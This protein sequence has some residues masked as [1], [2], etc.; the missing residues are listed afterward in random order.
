MECRQKHR[1]GHGQGT[2]TTYLEAA[3]GKATFL[4]IRRLHAAHG[5]A[6][7]KLQS[8]VCGRTFGEHGGKEHRTCEVKRTLGK[9]CHSC[10]VRD[11]EGQPENPMCCSRNV[12]SRMLMC[13]ATKLICTSN[14]NY[15]HT[16]QKPVTYV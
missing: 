12:E 11:E 5:R 13:K 9:H 10:G 4:V 6:I 14:E 2:G 7:F 16:G 8:G 3:S 15:E 1:Y